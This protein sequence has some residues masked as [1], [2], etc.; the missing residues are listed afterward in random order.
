MPQTRQAQYETRILR[1]I[2]HIN[3]H[4][5][6][7]LSLD[8]L[9]DV[10]CLSRF[11]FH[12]VFRGM[13]GQTVAE[14]VR[15]ARLTRASA[16]LRD[17][18]GVADVAGACGYGDAT[19]FS[20]AFSA[21]FG[22]PPGRFR[23]AHA[24]LRTQLQARDDQT[25]FPVEV[26][27][28]PACAGIGIQHRGSYMEIGIGFERLGAMLAAR[29]LFGQARTMLG[30]YYH[31]PSAVEEPFLESLAAVVMDGPVETPDGF[32]PVEIPAA[33]HAV[34]TFRGIIRG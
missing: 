13:T 21:A 3:A 30:I 28:V 32:V 19:S 15:N 29:G 7:T 20:R 27:N 1:V 17:G 25:T 34:M 6:E 33:R 9:A 23:D 12:R 4:A 24:A 31:D 5:T 26:R 18:A 2:A 10:A 11:H 22:V 14:A 8:D 16:L